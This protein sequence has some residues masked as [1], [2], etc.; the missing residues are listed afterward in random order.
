MNYKDHIIQLI[1]DAKISDQTAAKAMFISYGTFR[2]CK[3]DIARNNFT[4]K[5]YNDL[6][7]FLVEH[8]NE[9]I[10]SNKQTNLT[11]CEKEALKK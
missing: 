7:A 11:A 9:L 4:E 8:G 2:N 1:T 5:N 6:K 3:A 10:N